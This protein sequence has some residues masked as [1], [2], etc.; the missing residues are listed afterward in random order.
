MSTNAAFSTD[1]PPQTNVPSGDEFS[2]EEL[3]IL[4]G[5]TPVSA[6]EPSRSTSVPDDAPR[7]P[8]NDDTDDIDGVDE[9]ETED[10]DQPRDDKGRFVPKSAYLR[11][12]GEK[13][14]TYQKLATVAAELIRERERRATLSELLSSAAPQPEKPQPEREISPDE[15]IFGAY[16]QM[17]QKL[18]RLEQSLGQG[19]S[20]AKAQIQAMALQAEATRDLQAFATRQPA[21]ME[22][23]G[24]LQG[25]RN[26]ELEAL[27]VANPSERE[28]II[29]GEARDLIESALR[30]GTSAAERIWKLAQAR[31][32]K[33]QA[34]ADAPPI[35]PKAVEQI[36]RINKGKAA[37]TSLRGAGSTGETG[38]PLTLTRL[39][40]MSESEYLRTR[41]SYVAK[42][43]KAAWDR[44]TSGR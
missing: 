26:Q 1:A 39:A 12:K 28:Q 34:K 30:S 32:Y 11:V 24:Y 6:P 4:K 16:K 21:F 33:A 36:E 41:D 44:L 17:A 37:S 20:E 9:I 42:N 2:P 19:Q 31:G 14:A 13:D 43:G 40:D 22:A 18:Q 27:G 23:Y 35:D 7:E 25:Q 29:K 38:Q 5:E 8:A 3:S 15:D 10:P